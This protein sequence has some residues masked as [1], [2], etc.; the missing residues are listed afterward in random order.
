MCKS[1]ACQHEK[2][3]IK[4]CA[5]EGCGFVSG[6][7]RGFCS[8]HYRSMLK[9]GILEKI[10]RPKV[11]STIGCK[12]SGPIKRGFCCKCYQLEKR[13]GSINEKVCSVQGCG[14]PFYAKGFCDR[15]YRAARI[16]GKIDVATCKKNG[17][18]RPVYGL[19]MCRPCYGKARS[20]GELNFPPCRNHNC[21]KP[22]YA[23]GFCRRCYQSARHKGVVPGSTCKNNGCSGVVISYGLC[24]KCHQEAKS[25]LKG[26]KR[27]RYKGT[28]LSD[29]HPDIFAELI[30]KDK[31][32]G[33]TAGSQKFFDWRCRYCQHEWSAAVSDRCTAGRDRRKGSGC[34][35]CKISGFN[36]KKASFIYLISR[37]NQQKVGIANYGTGR[38]DTHRRNGWLIIEKIALPGEI[39]QILERGIKKAL[40]SKKIPTGSKAFRQPF[41]GYTEAWNSVDLEVR[42]IRGLCRK[43]GVKLEFY[44]SA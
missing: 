38:M 12:R 1:S 7:K 10:H 21:G 34:P 13:K 4:S 44:L 32:A 6:M 42:S 17:C 15:C 24:S 43:I 31:A 16:S 40:R 18:E 23:K 26:R 30:N 33:V 27:Q 25:R 29:T 36:I 41:D 11:C 35:A 39:A 20:G 3:A 8:S 5:V 14:S 22:I 28:R 19:G 2:E 37:P 9:N